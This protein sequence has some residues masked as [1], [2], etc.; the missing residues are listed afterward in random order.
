VSYSVLADN[1]PEVDSLSMGSGYANDIF[2]SFETGEVAAVERENWEIA[3]FTSGFSVGIITNGG[4]GIRLYN[5]PNGDTSNWN[6]IDTTGFLNWKL[7]FNST[8]TWEEGAFNRNALG[9]PDYGWGIYNM[10]NHHIVGDS[11]FILDSPF[12]GLKKLWIVEKDAVQNIY[13]FRYANLDG[14]DLQEVELNISEYTDKRFVYYSLEDNQVT[15]REPDSDRW[16]IL[17]TKYWELVPNNEGDFSPY[18]VTGV[19]SNVDITSNEFYPVGPDFMDWDSKP[20]DSIINNIGYDWKILTPEFSWEIKDSNYY[21]IRN[22]AGSIYKMWFEWWGGSSTGDFSFYK[23]M[24]GTVSVNEFHTSQE[25]LLVFPNPATNY[26]TIKT[27]KGL[28]GIFE[29]FLYDQNG[30]KVLSRVL[31]ENELKNNIHISNLNLPGGFYIVTLT[32]D[33]YTRSQSLIIR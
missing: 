33:N 10:N 30:R 31:S 6:S 19:L 4:I 11:L 7:L 20:M 3:F 32:G 23:Q 22:Y 9:H 21:F 29:I 13:R 18:I 25:S 24:V 14:T 5:Y 1:D 8:A 17:F 28:E 2:Y 16:D 12:S 15:D 27:P 26:L